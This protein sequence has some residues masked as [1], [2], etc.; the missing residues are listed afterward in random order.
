MFRIASVRFPVKLGVKPK[1][2]RGAVRMA[3][4][5]SR[6]ASVKK[7][8]LKVGGHGDQSE[9]I[10]RI[11]PKSSARTLCGMLLVPRG[12]RGNAWSL[13]VAGRLRRYPVFSAK[14]RAGWSVSCWADDDT[15]NFD[16]PAGQ[17]FFGVRF[18]PGMASAFMPE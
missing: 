17:Y 11:I 4:P 15:P 10:P 16:L 5:E 18:R 3:F 9:Q 7:K 12:F 2:D 8:K 13:R 6:S 1:V 14:R